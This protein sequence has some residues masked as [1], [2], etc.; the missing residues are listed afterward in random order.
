MKDRIQQVAEL[1]KQAQAI[2]DEAGRQAEQLLVQ[3]EQEAR[4]AL[5]RNRAETQ[6]EARLLVSQASVEAEGERVLASAEESN[7][8]SEALAMSN[9][10]RAV[11]YVLDRV[12]G[13]E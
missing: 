1:E 9:F 3:A 4:A 11:A 8:K 2:N 7:R 10:D 12:V 6:A 13:K 5:E